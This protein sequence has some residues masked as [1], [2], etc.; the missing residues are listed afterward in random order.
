VQL[1]QRKTLYE[2]ASS[3]FLQLF[4]SLPI[5]DN[6]SIKVIP[7]PSTSTITGLPSAKAHN[8][9]HD[10]FPNDESKKDDE[11]SSRII[12]HSIKASD[13]DEEGNESDLEVEDL[14]NGGVGGENAGSKRNRSNKGSKRKEKGGGGD[15]ELD[16]QAYFAVMKK[17]T[18]SNAQTAHHTV[19]YPPQSSSSDQEATNRTKDLFS[20]ISDQTRSGPA[21]QVSTGKKYR[22][23][24]SSRSKQQQQQQQQE[25]GEKDNEGVLLAPHLQ[26]LQQQKEE[27]SSRSSRS[28]H[29][30]HSAHSTTSSYRRNNLTI[31]TVNI[32][33]NE[34]K[35]N[36]KQVLLNEIR[37]R[38]EEE[39]SRRK[40]S[41]EDQR[42]QQ[43]SEDNRSTP[44]ELPYKQQPDDIAVG[45]S[46]ADDVQLLSSL[47]HDLD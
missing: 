34:V 39:S 6:E 3:D 4:T 21:E 28:A 18:S 42:Q 32:D 33:E 5:K 25:E 38:E 24:A 19:A 41:K 11:R 1:R 22:F 47:S 23:A 8:N 14:E 46:T 26:P 29:S 31:N 10:G 36:H 16:K 45:S 12:F 40:K 7:Y 43:M 44:E 13:D 17:S 9:S 2:K 27:R 35:A 37:R 30:S 20:P 15:S